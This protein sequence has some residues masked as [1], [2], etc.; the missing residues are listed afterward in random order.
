MRR[1]ILLFVVAGVMVG[2]VAVSH[3]SLRL[4]ARASRWPRGP[5]RLPA[6]SPS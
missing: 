4:R 3:L 6:E 1:L 2:L 5:R